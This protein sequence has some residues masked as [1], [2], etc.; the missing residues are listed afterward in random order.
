MTVDDADL[1]ELWTW[2]LRVKSA[3]SVVDQGDWPAFGETGR[4]TVSLDSGT[5]AG[6]RSRV[7]SQSSPQSSLTTPPGG[8]A[9]PIAPGA[10][11]RKPA[12]CAEPRPWNQHPA[13]MHHD[14]RMH[15]WNQ[16]FQSPPVPDRNQGGERS[17]A[18]GKI[19]KSRVAGREL[20]PAWAE[21]KENLT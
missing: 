7:H 19:C 6:L 5:A 11:Q 8:P 3:S 18:G 12:D 17:R 21:N 13:K 16:S 4:V 15:G 10:E 1:E 14:R 20:S 2:S 9:V